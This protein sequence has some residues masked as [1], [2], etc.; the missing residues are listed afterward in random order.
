M[1]YAVYHSYY[2]PAPA[3]RLAARIA[4]YTQRYGKPALIGEFGVDAAAWSPAWEPHLRGFRQNLWAGALG[5]GAATGLSW[6]WEDVHD[7]HALGQQAVLEKF[8]RDTGW[9]E[10]GWTPVAVDGSLEAPADLGEPVSDA[11][12]FNADLVLNNFRRLRLDGKF[13]VANPLAAERASEH[14]SSVLWGSREPSAQRPLRLAVHAADNARLTVRVK[15]TTGEALLVG[16]VDDA[17]VWRAPFDQ[18]GAIDREFSTPLAPG[19]HVIEIANA[20]TERIN[21]ASLRVAGLRPATFSGGW[22]YRPEA[23]GIRRGDRAAL[24]VVAPAAVY[25]AGAIRY[26]L[27]AVVGESITLTGWPNGEFAAHWF[28][29]E[30]GREIARTGATASGGQLL[31]SLPEFSVDLAAR[32]E[33]E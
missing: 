18:A 11:P 24:Y 7:D 14:L 21:L 30:T 13:A 32:I 29:P 8:L 17:E 12:P 22:R 19:R 6:W 27:P 26:Q 31:L 1:E 2:E 28:D 16:R 5:G 25:P 10:G 9:F 33:R 23:F 3:R 20:G 4:D 15:D